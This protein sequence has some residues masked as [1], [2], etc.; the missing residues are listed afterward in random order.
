MARPHDLADKLDALTANGLYGQWY[1]ETALDWEQD[2][3]VPIWMSND[4]YIS[5]ISQLYYGEMATLRMC[6]RLVSE[7]AEPQARRFLQTQIADE[8]RH[9]RV[10]EGYLKRLGGI[11]PMHASVE[12]A[13]ETGFAWTGS[14]HGIIVAFHVMLEGE[15][16]RA[17]ERF[18]TSFPCPLFRQINKKVSR[19]EARHIAFG[20][21]YLRDRL[22]ALPQDERFEIFRW[23][24][25][26]WGECVHAAMDH[27]QIPGV[28]TPRMRRNWMDSRWQKQIKALAD[29]GLVAVDELALVGKI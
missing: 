4:V 8:F 17:Q 10:Y 14:Y 18:A 1:A 13:R 2:V 19:D 11:A 3:V 21:I 16:L 23:V 29:I 22:A 27:Y 26:I 25:S 20:K 6:C 5:A 24:R 9:A 15:A 12:L 7:L 28:I